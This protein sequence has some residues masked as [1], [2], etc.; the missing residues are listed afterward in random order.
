MKFKQ[1]SSYHYSRGSGPFATAQLCYPSEMI[2][3]N[4]TE[5]I[6][7]IDRCA[8]GLVREINLELEIITVIAGDQNY[9]QNDYI[10]G[11]FMA[12]RFSY[13]RGLALDQAG[14]IYLSESSSDDDASN[15]IRFLNMTSKKT[16]TV[17]GYNGT[18]GQVDGSP[19]IASFCGLRGIAVD[20]LGSVYLADSRNAVIRK[21]SY[22]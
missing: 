2:F 8:A 10:D 7:M 9:F 4:Y 19:Q 5:K 1:I 21:L 22:Q 17:S 11:P 16:S 6:Y 14:N 18:C 13:L 3:N 20:S 15:R 12:A